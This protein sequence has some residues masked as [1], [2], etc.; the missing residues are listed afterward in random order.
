MRVKL[1][2]D[3]FWEG[4]FPTFKKGEKVILKE[5]CTHYLYW[6]ACEINGYQTYIPDLFV[7]DNCLIRDYNPT[8]LILEKDEII[9]IIE[10]L[11]AWFLAKD[12][13]G[14]IGWIPAEKCARFAI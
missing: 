13:N 2:V 7:K 4:Q 6:S 11:H 12:K 9:D 3:H 8:E 1:M 5:K 14:L 10:V